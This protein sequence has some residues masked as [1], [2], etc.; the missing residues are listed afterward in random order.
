MKLCDELINQ[1][2][3]MEPN[4]PERRQLAR[5][6]LEV[7]VRLRIPETDRVSYA[8]TRNVSA[9]GIYFHTQTPLII[10]QELECVL[11]LP[12][13]LTSSP[14]P[15]LIGCRAM[16]LRLNCELP[17]QT[18]GVAVEVHSYDFSWQGILS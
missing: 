10:G 18:I 5:F 17:S 9:R 1:D 4:P 14:A 12:E 6:S 16:V 11:I 2:S 13:K 3:A 15:V 7:F 8:L